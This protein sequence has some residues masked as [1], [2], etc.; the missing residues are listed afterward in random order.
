MIYKK[1]FISL[2]LYA[3]L[4]SNSRAQIYAV[5]EFIP[6]QL[7]FMNLVQESFAPKFK[8]HSTF[9]IGL[10]F[11]I[12]D[13]NYNQ[14]TICRMGKF[15]TSFLDIDNNGVESK[16][17]VFTSGTLYNYRIG[18]M[19]IMKRK[20]GRYLDLTY[21]R[22]NTVVPE[23]TLEHIKMNNNQSI[24]VDANNNP[25]AYYGL[26]LGVSYSERVYKDLFFTLNIPCS[27]RFL[28]HENSVDLLY[29]GSEDTLLS[30]FNFLVINPNLSLSYRIR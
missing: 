7:T 5:T 25:A 22:M 13:H 9:S 26:A 6:G 3:I 8:A 10:Q 23:N 30:Y 16:F 15:E 18:R 14:L 27:L 21:G 24:V 1:I 28:V 12:D 11:F 29:I 17:S 19:N 20:W 4:S 2:F